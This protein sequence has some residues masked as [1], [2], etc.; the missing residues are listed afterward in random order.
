[1]ETA[2]WVVVAKADCCCCCRKH[3]THCQARSFPLELS[4][5]L[6][7]IKRKYIRTHLSKV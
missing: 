4:F 5:D 3:Q 6:V 7:V 1:M 2:F